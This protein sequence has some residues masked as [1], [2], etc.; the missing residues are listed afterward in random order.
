MI[1]ENIPFSF[2]LCLLNH[3]PNSSLN[4]IE[5]KKKPAW[6]FFFITVALTESK[7]TEAF[8]AATVA[9]ALMTAYVDI[10]KLVEEND[11]GKDKF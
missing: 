9:H 2:D 3:G 10:K 5:L 1:K 7:K 8:F 6:S 4:C 11:I